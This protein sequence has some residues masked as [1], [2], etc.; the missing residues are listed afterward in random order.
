MN[1]SVTPAKAGQKVSSPVE[2]TGTIKSARLIKR[3]DGTPLVSIDI[4]GLPELYNV[5][6][7]GEQRKA[8]ILRTR[9]EILADLSGFVDEDA[10]MEELALSVD[11][12]G[13]KRPVTLMVSAHEA[14]ALTI[15][16]ENSK[17]AIASGATIGSEIEANSAGFYV[18]GFLDIDYSA[19][20][21]LKRLEQMRKARR[22]AND[23]VIGD[24][25]D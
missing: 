6:E 8:T 13:A 24:D 23:D 3:K 15:V 5:N 9:K 20:L 21:K 18:Q 2:F 14:G 1:N 16:T 25:E 12:Y 19:D 7:A 17:R 10:S 11:A 22:D 4:K